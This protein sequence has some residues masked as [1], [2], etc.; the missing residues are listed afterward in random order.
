MKLRLYPLLNDRVA[1]QVS[2]FVLGATL[3]LIPVFAAQAEA[4]PTPSA[5]SAQVLAAQAGHVLVQF[6]PEAQARMVTRETAQG[7]R[8]GLASFDRQLGALGRVAITPL[9]DT[10]R[11]PEAHR[12]AGTDRIYNVRYTTDETPE[13]VAARLQASSDVVFAEV[14]QIAHKASTTPNDTFFNLQWGPRNPGPSP[15]AWTEDC[16]SD[17]TLIWDYTTG[18]PDMIVAVLDTGID[19]LHPEFAGRLLPGFDY[20][21]GDADPND[22]DGHGTS[23]AGILAAMGNNNIGVAGLAW[24]VQIIPVQVLDAAGSGLH[25]WIASGIMFAVDNGAQILSLSLG[26]GASGTMSSAVNYG[27]NAGALLFCATG[28]DNASSISYPAR[29]TN[30]V[31]V[32]ALSPCDER[33]NPSSCDGENWWGSNYGTGIDFLAPGVKMYTTDITGSGGYAVGDYTS[34]F[35]GTSSATP[36][37]AGVAALV[38]SMFPAKTN[39]Q[40]WDLLRKSSIDMGAAGYDLETGYGRINGMSALLADFFTNDTQAAIALSAQDSRGVSWGDVD[41]DGDPDLY[42]TQSS[43]NT[44]KLFRND[45]GVFVDVTTAALA[46]NGNSQGAAFGDADNDGD[47]DLYLANDAANIY[48]RNDA[49]T[50]V[51]ATVAPLDNTGPGTTTSWIDVENDGD[52]DLYV[53]NY[54]TNNGLFLNDGSGLFTD[55]SVFPINDQRLG[56]GHAWSDWDNDGDMEVYIANENLNRCLRNNGDGTFTI[57]FTENVAAAGVAFADFDNDGDMDFYLAIEGDDSALFVNQGDGTFLKNTYGELLDNGP[58]AGVAWGDFDNDGYIDLLLTSDG[59]LNKLLHNEEGFTFSAVAVLGPTADPGSS[60]GVAWADYDCDGDLD[61]YVVNSNSS[62]VLVRNDQTTGN[63]WLQVKLN[64]DISNARGVGSRVRIVTAAGQQI[65]EIDA[66]GGLRSQNEKL[67]HFG[68]GGDTL[69]DS[70]VVT[71]PSGTEDVA[72]NVTVDQKVT[73]N[74]GMGVATSVDEVPDFLPGTRLHLAQNA[75]NPFQGSTL[76]RYQLQNE[77]AVRLTVFGADGRLVRTLVDKDQRAGS[78]LAVWDRRDETGRVAPAGVYF[79][80]LDA[81]GERQARRMISIE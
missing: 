15:N 47:E 9:F 50:F 29:Y 75:P 26:G 33:K 30:A 74:E 59:G 51:N 63:H 36:H 78:Y 46:G 5:I 49:G 27:Y 31:A 43:G 56:R 68:L 73:I 8:T 42:V 28:N 39:Q 40:I 81:A 52:L 1:V 80:Q 16:D 64:G 62:N 6:T 24:N 25:S 35:N 67:A 38:W 41:D 17:A 18:D 44:N 71:W 7:D 19:A 60:G 72:T 54:G 53:E 3:M 34:S 48:L 79:Y 11:N 65:R 76:I 23:C 58:S 61:Y 20:V 13:E 10:S 4:P 14:D 55:G 69:V 37:A 12:A 32:G 2:R 77:S 70:L 21:N 66:G 22:Q 57:A 45:N